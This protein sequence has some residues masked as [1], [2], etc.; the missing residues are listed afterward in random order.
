MIE[1]SERCLRFET[2]GSRCLGVRLEDDVCLVHLMREDAYIV[3]HHPT[4]ASVR[5][6]R[7]RCGANE[8]P[9]STDE[10]DP[11]VRVAVYRAA[12]TALQSFRD[13]RA[14][15]RPIGRDRV[16]IFWE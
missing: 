12:M 13:A 14:A 4:G 1:D 6:P 3:F 7:T 5:V 15:W 8:I 2:D 9:R 11:V 10:R 16:Y